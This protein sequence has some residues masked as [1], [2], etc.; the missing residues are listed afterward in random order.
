MEL[1]GLLGE[2]R[3]E[4]LPVAVEDIDAGL[5]R[6]ARVVERRDFL[7][8]RRGGLHVAVDARELRL[9][10]L[11]LRLELRDVARRVVAPAPQVALACIS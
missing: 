8:V 4:R 11:D 1:R 10:R 7:R 5:E 3:L 6:E 9:E 2:E